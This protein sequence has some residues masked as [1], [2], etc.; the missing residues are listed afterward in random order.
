MFTKSLWSGFSEI[1]DY[2][3]LQRDITVDVAVIGGG[4][5]GISA[6]NLLSQK[7]MKAAILES[8]KVG[9]GTTSHSTG[10][11]YYT[12]DKILTSLQSKYDIKT[13]KAVAESRSRAMK[14][15]AAWVQ[16]YELDCDYKSVPWY[17]YSKTENSKDKID[18]E[19]NTGREAGLDILEASASEIPF[20]S[21]HAIK[22][23]RQAQINPM[24]YIQELAKAIQD[25][26]C[27]I[28]EHTHVSSVEEEK[29][30]CV[31][32]TS[33]G[34]VTAKYVI[35]ATHIPKGVMVVQSLLGPYREYGI[36]CRT[37]GRNHPEGIYW[38]YY[39]EGKKISTRN[40]ERNGQ[41][42]LIVV[43]EPHKVGHAESNIQ[44]IKRLESFAQKYFNIQEVAFRWGGQH[45]RPADLLPY[46]GPRK[47]NS[48]EFIATG[49]STD[50]LTYGTLAGMI[51]A[52]LITGRENPWAELYD[53]TRKQPLKSV[54]KFLK[55]NIDVAKE[56]LK[57]FRG[58][59]ED[60]RLNNL[61]AGEAKVIEKDG[62]KLAVY[63]ND[64]GKLEVYSAI[65]THMECIVNWND[66]E[67]SWDCPCHGSRFK[68]DGTVLEGPAFHPL[69]KVRFTGDS[70]EVKD[71]Y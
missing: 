4:I 38:G 14:Q 49:Y 20:P 54:S 36:A 58:T 41:H 10:N 1:Y 27:L 8:R 30:R 52:D 56:Y 32:T 57:D 18:E 46:I 43:G 11:L 47:K 24:R 39:E 25:E 6:G 63:K 59:A 66:A 31:L 19:V 61:K 42:F 55:E 44:H 3:Q 2:P 12:I 65:C 17:L 53:S 35:H 15:I 29:D 70:V 50:G 37:T 5:T 13:I 9:G 62:E 34:K 26:S 23:P 64:D 51:L 7:G 60:T 33:G 28:Y 21:V 69:H 48:R 16:E 67:K 40:Y 71:E 22:V 68:V 45:Y